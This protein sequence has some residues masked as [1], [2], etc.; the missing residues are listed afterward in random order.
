MRKRI[1]SVESRQDGKFRV[2]FRSMCDHRS[3]TVILLLIDKASLGCSFSRVY[4]TCR[5]LMDV[6]NAPWS[7]RSINRSISKL[8]FST[9]EHEVV[10]EL[11]L[12][13]KTS[14]TSSSLFSSWLSNLCPL[15]KLESVSSRFI[16]FSEQ[17]SLR[18]RFSLFVRW[19]FFI[20]F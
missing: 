14:S 6:S 9:N 5:D 10:M 13:R 11:F 1:F 18:P 20:F 2:E 19:F 7:S 8:D 12:H 17:F 3:A 15:E 16:P 4:Y